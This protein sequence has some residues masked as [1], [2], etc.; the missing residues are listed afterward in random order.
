MK[1]TKCLFLKIVGLLFFGKREGTTHIRFL[2]SEEPEI[3][4][5]GPLNKFKVSYPPKSTSG[6]K[7]EVTK[8]GKTETKNIK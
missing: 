6:K 1:I 3:F 4:V 2:R 8:V 5:I 7:F